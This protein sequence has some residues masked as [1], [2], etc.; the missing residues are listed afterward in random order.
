MA[1]QRQSLSLARRKDTSRAAAN[2]VEKRMWEIVYS[3][4]VDATSLR[5][6]WVVAI[7]RCGCASLIT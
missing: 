5:A 6:W 4:T 1:V 3:K 7:R 2:I